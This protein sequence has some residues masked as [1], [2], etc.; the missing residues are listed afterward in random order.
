VFYLIAGEQ[1]QQKLQ[2]NQAQYDHM[3]SNA[4]KI[5]ERFGG[6]IKVM[7]TGLQAGVPRQ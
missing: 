3:L 7:P 1:T 5:E 6:G 2:I 4:K